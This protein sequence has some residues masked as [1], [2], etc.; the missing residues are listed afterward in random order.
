MEERMRIVP[1]A[2]ASRIFDRGQSAP[3]PLRPIQAQHLEPVAGQVGV[4]D[5]GVVPRAQDDAIV[6]CG[7]I[8]LAGDAWGEYRR[9]L[10]GYAGINWHDKYIIHSPYR[11]G[12]GR[13]KHAPENSP[14]NIS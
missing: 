12:Y 6:G 1:E 2:R 10:D 9:L 7:H 4:Q 13:G 8:R 5:Q 3:R 11:L 14:C